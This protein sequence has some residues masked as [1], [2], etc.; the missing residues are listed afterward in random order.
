MFKI[1]ASANLPPSSFVV[2]LDPPI[3][4]GERLIVE[5]PLREPTFAEIRKAYTAISSDINAATIASRDSILLHLVSGLTPK[6]VDALPISV[7][8]T[9]TAYLAPFFDGQRAAG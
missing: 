2:E 7:I 8:N 4:I 1:E 9:C 5:I 3:E 6:E